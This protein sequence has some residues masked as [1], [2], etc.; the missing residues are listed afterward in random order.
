MT[1]DVA[2]SRQQATQIDTVAMQRYGVPGLVL[3]ENAG[4]Q[5]ALA[6][7]EMLGSPAGRSVGILCGAGNN[8]G[9]GFVI[10]RHLINRGVDAAVTLLVSVQKVIERDNEASVNLSILL[11]SGVPVR[12]AAGESDIADALAADLIVDAMLG[13]GVSGEVKAP[14][15]PAIEALNASGRPVLAVDVP[16][17]LDCDTGRPLGVAV[18]ARCTVTFVF[19]KIGFTRP[20]ACEYTG[21]IRVADIGVPRAALD[22]LTAGW[23]TSDEA[24]VA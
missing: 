20:G 19:N 14:F 21:R 17:G 7:A 1:P 11:K 12:E 18:R 2:V 23:R 6:A 22:E 13:T 3:M 15:R 8:G 9:D 24:P 16:S 4:R 10:A 5:C